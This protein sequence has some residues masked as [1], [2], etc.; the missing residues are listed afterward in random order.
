MTEDDKPSRIA[1]IHATN[2]SL[3]SQVERG[4]AK[5]RALSLGTAVVAALLTASYLY[6]IALGVAGPRSVTV[7]LGDPVLLAFEAAL[8]LLVAA[9][10]GLSLKNYRFVTRLSREIRAARAEEEEFAAKYG[11]A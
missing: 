1:T 9:W 2:E 6:Q 8:T 5:M 11:L 10:L 7:D 3:I 4:S